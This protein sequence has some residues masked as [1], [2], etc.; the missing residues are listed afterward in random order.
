MEAA[1]KQPPTAALARLE[2]YALGVWYAHLLTAPRPTGSDRAQLVERAT[3]LRARLL[4]AADAL[5]DAGLLD[6]QA[7]ENIRKGAGHVDKAND[8]VAL[9]ALFV[10]H[11]DSI[12]KKTAITREQIEEAETLGPTLLVAL[13]DSPDNKPDAALEARQRA[14]TLLARAYDEVRRAVHFVRWHEDDADAYTLSIY[15]RPRGRRK[16]SEAHSEDSAPS[17]DSD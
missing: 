1:F 11:W 17:E 12:E 9:T 13:S 4:K 5:A 8:L 3:H 6:P 7:V 15:S 14:F 2:T 16:A 10:Q